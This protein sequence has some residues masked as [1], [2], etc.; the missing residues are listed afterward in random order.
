M[1]KLIEHK[2]EK[3][4]SVEIAYNSHQIEKMKCINGRKWS[5]SKKLWHFPVKSYVIKELIVIF[6]IE[7]VPIEIRDLSN[8]ES[9]LQVKYEETENKILL[10]L[11]RNDKDIEF[12][13]SLK[14]HSWNKE[15]MF[16]LVS[17]TEEN[18][19]QI[20][21]YFGR[22]LYRGKI[23]GLLKEKVKKAPLTK[24]L[25]VYE[26]IKGRLK[27]IFTYN[28]SLRM[29]IKE[30]PYTR[31]DSKNKWWTTVDNSFVR[32]QLNTFCLQEQWKQHYY[33]KPEEEICARPHKDQIVNYRKCPEEYINHLKLGKGSC[34]MWSDQRKK[35]HYL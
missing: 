26:H 12:I 2:K 34:I 33:K 1:I 24:E 25:H 32:E 15:K 11:K 16:W 3:R 23:L 7:K 30:F 19:K 18:K 6:G 4:I 28:D 17:K 35:N 31:W 14:Y 20:A 22:R 5:A 9:L 13:K 29:L 27:L 21:A 8:E 10:Q